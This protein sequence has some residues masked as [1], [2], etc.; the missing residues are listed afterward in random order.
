VSRTS[1]PSAADVGALYKTASIAIGRALQPF[2]RSK[3]SRRVSPHSAFQLG[4][5]T[6]TEQTCHYSQWSAPAGQAAVI[7]FPQLACERSFCTAYPGRLHR[8]RPITARRLAT[9]LPL[10]S[11]PRAG[12]FASLAGN[13]VS[14]FP[15]STSRCVIAPRSCLLDAGGSIGTVCDALLFIAATLIPFWSRRSTSQFRHLIVTTL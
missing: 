7:C 3:R 15:D 4:R 11:V 10:P 6:L 8:V 5:S 1:C 2:P 12:I 9:M 14:E 13:V